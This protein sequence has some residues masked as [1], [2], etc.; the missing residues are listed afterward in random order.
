MQFREDQKQLKAVY[1]QIEEAYK[2]P[3]GMD[4]KYLIAD[5]ELTDTSKEKTDR[6]KQWL[7]VRS[8][9]IYIDESVKILNKMITQANLAKVN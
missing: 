5:N 3:K 1:K 2:L 8:E 7:K 9:D 4:M 6:S